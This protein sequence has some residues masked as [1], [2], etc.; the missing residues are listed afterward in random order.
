[1][2][3][4]DRH[5]LA[6]GRTLNRRLLLH[7][8]CAPCMTVTEPFLGEQGFESTAFF[9]NP[10]IHPWREWKRRLDTLGEWVSRTGTPLVVD[11]SYPLEENVSMLVG[12]EPRCAACF[13]DR[14]SKA[15]CKAFE[16]G[17][18]SFSTTLMLSPYA[19]HALLRSAGEEAS[20][21]TGVP[22]VYNDL[23]HLYGRSVEL[24]RA[25]GLYRQPY[26]GC[27]FSERDRFARGSPGRASSGASS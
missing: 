6:G 3:R 5:V 24:S 15:A 18:D 9:Y 16:C 21:R 25:A 13:S 4:E 19:D 22:F 2:D 10:N 11:D 14:L 17:C 8:C 23:R 26:C 12:S 7:V 1:M 20:A 27:I